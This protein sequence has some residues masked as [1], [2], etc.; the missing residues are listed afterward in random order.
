MEN[1]RKLSLLDCVSNTLYELKVTQEIFD[2]ARE[3]TM[4][5]TQLLEHC[6]FKECYVFDGPIEAYN[7]E[8][9]EMES[10]STSDAGTLEADPF[11]ETP[12]TSFKS[13]KANSMPEKSFD[14]PSMAKKASD[15]K[16]K[17][18]YW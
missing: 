15:Q 5:A 10:Q 3:D 2:R 14:K 1:L 18:K 7:L 17:K 8:E 4:F 9:T 16:K 6:K 13:F 11:C 12:S